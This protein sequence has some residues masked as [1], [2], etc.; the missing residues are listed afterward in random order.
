MRVISVVSGKGGTGKTT[1]T[2]N[3]AAFLSGSLGLD[4][5]AVD[6]NITTP[7]L[8]MFLGMEEFP[9]SI[10]HVIRGWVDLE[11]AV[12]RHPTGLRVLP[13][14]HSLK[15]SKNINP[16]E[17]KNVVGE[18]CKRFKPEIV[19]LDCAP[20]FGREAIAGMK[21]GK[22]ILMVATPHITSITDT[23]K[24]KYIADKLGVKPLGMVLNKTGYVRNEL[25]SKEIEEIVGVPV[26]AS[27]PMD[28]NMEKCS[29]E[30]KI[31]VI[32]KPRSKASRNMKR[33]AGKI[34]DM[35]I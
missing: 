23:V 28:K 6:C 12:Y 19:I 7:H 4:V 14:S 31:A 27:I 34:L 24:S 11:D 22:E 5:L 16:S 8:G 21:T 13:A 30:N 2:T 25:K 20:G 35:G 1:I 18:A 3:L 9:V 32:H 26:M 33:L 10:N 17:I 15:D 29:N